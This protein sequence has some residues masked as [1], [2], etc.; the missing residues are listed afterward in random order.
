MLNFSIKGG[1]LVD[2]PLI[3]LAHAQSLCT[4]EVAVSGPALSHYGITVASAVVNSSGQTPVSSTRLNSCDYGRSD[5]LFVLDTVSG[6]HLVVD[7]LR[8]GLRHALFQLLRQQ[9]AHV[10]HAVKAVCT[11]IRSQQPQCH[12][13]LPDSVNHLF[14]FPTQADWY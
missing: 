11:I 13:F 10:C 9:A 1:P 4:A 12:L 3:I 5:A 14:T 7:L 6:S 8:H 2:P